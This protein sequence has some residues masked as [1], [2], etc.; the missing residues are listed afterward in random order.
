MNVHK[1]IKIITI[2]G[3]II[4]GI[5]R[6]LQEVEFREKRGRYDRRHKRRRRN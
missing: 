4:S 5:G 2:A 3:T 6:L 1:V